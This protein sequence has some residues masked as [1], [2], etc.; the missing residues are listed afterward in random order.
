MARKAQLPDAWDDDDWETQADKAAA[1]P[2]AP[3]PAPAPLSKRERAAQHAESNKK[4]WQAAE[5]PNNGVPLQYLSQQPEPPLAQTFKAPPIVL[6]RKPVLA[7]R[8]PARGGMANLSLADS[9]DEDKKPQ[10]TPEQRKERQKREYEEKQR[11]YAEARAKI[12]GESSNGGSGNSK[13]GSGR[14][15]G[16]TT[17]GTTTPPRDRRG[18]GRGRGGP[19]GRGD[20]I[21]H[22]RTDSG[23]SAGTDSRDEGHGRERELYDPN[24]SPR[25]AV[26]VESR[27]GFPTSGQSTPRK[28]EQTIRAPR[29]PDGSGRGGFGFARRGAQGD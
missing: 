15:S 23:R 3:E 25:P 24:Y 11:L 19:R 16:T 29:G 13:A 6:A 12:F 18:R 22:H 20:R 9:D 7:K 28:A 4:L 17:P 26:P 14:S 10:E 21:A 27:T 8:D 1:E 2:S 5:E